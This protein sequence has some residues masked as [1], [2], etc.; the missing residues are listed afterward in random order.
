MNDI[1]LHLLALALAFCIV[2]TPVQGQKLPQSGD[3]PAVTRVQ[4]AGVFVRRAFNDEAMIVVG[5]HTAN[6]TVG[7]EHMMLEVAMTTLN[8]HRVTLG[9]DDVRLRTPTSESLPL[10]SQRHFN[11]HSTELAMLVALADTQ[12]DSLNYLPTAAN[13][14]C[15]IRFFVD[16]AQRGS[17][18]ASDELLVIPEHACVGRLYFEVP[19]GTQ[20]GNHALAIK[21]DETVLEVPFR[22]RTKQETADFARAWR[23]KVKASKKNKKKRKS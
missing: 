14:L 10:M 11:L 12:S 4:A 13:V 18:V 3:E 15:P 1:K 22:L 5:F 17:G 8:D 20:Y 7:Q 2:G 19:G 9:V 21:F 23:E 6:D 16:P